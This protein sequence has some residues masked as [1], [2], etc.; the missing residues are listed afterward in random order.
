[1]PR[2]SPRLQSTVIFLFGDD[3]EVDGARDVCGSGV[4]IGLNHPRYDPQQQFTRDTYAVTA[5]HAVRQGGSIIRL[6]TKDGGS[7]YLELDPSEWT[8]S[9]TDDVAAVDLTER[10]EEG[11][12]VVVIHESWLADKPII[13][14][15]QIGIGEDAFALGLFSNIPGKVRNVVTGRFGN[16]SMMAHPEAPIERV[17]GPRPAHL[18][19][20]KSR[21]GLSGSPVFVYRT[22]SSD[23]RLIDQGAPMPDV[24][25]GDQFAPLRAMEQYRRARDNM[26]VKLLGIHSAQFTDFVQ[27]TRNGEL[28]PE[29]SEPIRDGDRL[30]IPNSMAVVV[31]ADAVRALLNHPSLAAPRA[32]RHANDP[33][34]NI[35]L[36]RT[37]YSGWLPNRGR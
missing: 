17:G 34:E 12:E 13:D 24:L 27:V 2:F 35:L 36:E 26:F 11:D 6:N 28:A 4:L 7:R 1:M 37:V 29:I 10:L 5:A 31:P 15:Y 9:A 20:M 8:F 3:P 16:V 22:P 18:F 25:P 14:R 30:R 19:D 21:P 33:P 23:L 32:S